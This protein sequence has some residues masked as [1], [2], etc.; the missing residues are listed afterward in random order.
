MNMNKLILS[1]CH[2]L[3]FKDYRIL[4]VIFTIL[5]SYLIS[6]TFYNL[7]VRKPTYNSYERR[8]LSVEDYPE[9]IVCPEPSTNITALTSRGYKSAE[10]YYKGLLFGHPLYTNESPVSWAGNK[11]N[12]G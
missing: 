6:D 4:K 2:S 8:P 1:Y 5:A 9:I 7:L 12:R 11:Q 3:V 10:Y